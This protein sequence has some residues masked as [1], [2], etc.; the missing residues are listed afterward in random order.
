MA[1]ARRIWFR[2]SEPQYR[3]MKDEADVKGYLTIS[4]YMRSKIFERKSG[5]ANT[6]RSSTR[7]HSH[8]AMLSD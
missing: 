8:G 4:S 5:E 1:K 7:V 6:L 3:R 2:V